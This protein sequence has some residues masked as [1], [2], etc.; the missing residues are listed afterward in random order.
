MQ[1][2]LS[3]RALHAE[4]EAIVE[5]GRVVATILVD[6]Q[7]VGD[8]AELQQAMPILVRA[9]QAGSFERENGADVAHRHVADQRLEVLAVG[10]PR[11]GL[12]EVPVEDPD[13]L[14]GPAECLRLARQIGL[15]LRA[16]LV[17][18]DLRHC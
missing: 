8:G 2:G 13:P 4:H 9:R 17:E 10:R 6:H 3:E 15:A 12:T 11:T 1:L 14:R 7:R 18:A 16:L 5:L